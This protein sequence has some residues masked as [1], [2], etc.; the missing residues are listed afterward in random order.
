MEKVGATSTTENPSFQF[1]ES[2]ETEEGEAVLAPAGDDDGEDAEEAEGDEPEDEF[3]E[4][5]E[6]LDLARTIYEREKEGGKAVQ[7]ELGDCY[8]LL[9][10]VSLE[11][12]EAVV[13]DSSW[14]WKL[15]LN[16]DSGAQKTSLKPLKTTNPLSPASS[17]R[18]LPPH[19]PSPKRI[20]SWPLC[21][22]RQRTVVRRL[23]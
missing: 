19:R 22:S 1:S 18:F 4:A 9:G 21:S 13:S 12:G 10:D 5:W 20:T 17:P 3:N 16:N 6:V 7:K 11:T 2:V 23:C 8:L 14:R 15:G